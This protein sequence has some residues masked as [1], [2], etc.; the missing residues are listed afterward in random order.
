MALQNFTM[1]SGDRKTVTV[2]VK[3]EAAAAV[4]I[5]SYASIIWGFFP[6]SGG[7]VGAQALAL[8]LS[9]NLAFTTDGTD[10]SLTATFLDTETAALVGSYVHQMWVKTDTSKEYVVMDG[11]V[12]FLLDRITS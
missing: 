1:M 2:L 8:E 3:N 12:N 6:I 9:G 11:R 4:D 10:G 7:V 5:S